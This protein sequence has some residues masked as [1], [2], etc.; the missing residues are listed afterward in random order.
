[1]ERKEDKEEKGRERR[2]EGVNPFVT[3]TRSEK[4]REGQGRGGGG[5]RGGGWGRGRGGRDA[6]VEK[7][8]KNKIT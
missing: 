3:L 8:G 1:M 4:G 7:G 2:R 5:G 6:E